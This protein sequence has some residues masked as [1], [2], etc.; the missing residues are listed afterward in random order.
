[1]LF[2]WILEV[3]PP[4]LSVYEVTNPLA[5]PRDHNVRTFPSTR[6]RAGQTLPPGQAVMRTSNFSDK[7]ERQLR[8]KLVTL[9]NEMDKMKFGGTAIKAVGMR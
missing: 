5:P 7:R 8:S 4:P 3:W 9:G 2:C 1:M 6:V